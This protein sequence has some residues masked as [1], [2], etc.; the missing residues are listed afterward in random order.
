MAPQL[1]HVILEHV[2]EGGFVV[3]ASI[4]HA[5][6]GISKEFSICLSDCGPSLVFVG[7][8]VRQ[9]HVRR[10][11]GSLGAKRAVSPPI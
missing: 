4:M 6:C 1:G 3:I 2:Q 7:E 5:W 8:L 9:P 11:Q 10:K